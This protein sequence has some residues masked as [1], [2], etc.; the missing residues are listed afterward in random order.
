MSIWTIVLDPC[1]QGL[2]FFIFLMQ[3][4]PLH[5][6]TWWVCWVCER[7][8]L[9]GILGWC[10]LK[11]KW[12]AWLD[13]YWMFSKSQFMFVQCRYIAALRILN[14][15]YYW[16]Q[17]I[18]KLRNEQYMVY[19]HSGMVIDVYING[20]YP[21]TLEFGSTITK[22]YIWYG[23]MVCEWDKHGLI[24]AHVCICATIYYKFKVVLKSDLGL[25]VLSTVVSWVPGRTGNSIG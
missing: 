5:H 6:K 15:C 22:C 10:C 8:L 11:V 1:S 25:T 9:G 2:W 14:M 24:V 19:L 4:Y 18:R 7:N 16:L 20:D 13:L 21:M 12:C 23:F 3:D 17:G